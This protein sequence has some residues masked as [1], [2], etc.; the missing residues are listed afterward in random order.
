[1]WALSEDLSDVLVLQTNDILTID[2]S[3]VMV[4]QDT[5]PMGGEGHKYCIRYVVGMLLGRIL[6]M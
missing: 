4:Y 3:Q 2:L 6:V 1:M 5:I